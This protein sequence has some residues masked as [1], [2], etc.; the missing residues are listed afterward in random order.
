MPGTYLL[1][2][3]KEVVIIGHLSPMMTSA[4]T[5]PACE[6]V[7]VMTA[8]EE[9]DFGHRT[10]PSVAVVLRIM[11]WALQGWECVQILT[12]WIIATDVQEGMPQSSTG[13]AGS[14]D[15]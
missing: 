11:G 13:Q 2:A 8:M 4:I 1:K 10:P 6:C 12:P 9:V 15:R 14:G 7:W 5:L 3:V